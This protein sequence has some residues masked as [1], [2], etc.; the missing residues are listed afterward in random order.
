MDIPYVASAASSWFEV[1]SLLLNL[2]LGG[3]FIFTFLTLHSYKI[4]AR[5]EALQATAQAEVVKQQ[6]DSAEIDNVEKIAK[7]WREQA[8]AFETLWKSKEDQMKALTLTV[9]ELKNEVH[10]LVGINTKI[11]KSLDKINADNYEKIIE[12]IKADIHSDS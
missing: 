8:L 5:G 12:Q 11:V 3:G 4:K 9:E 7:M 10:R 1:I 6:A 2:V